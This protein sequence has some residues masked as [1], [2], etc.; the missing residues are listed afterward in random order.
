MIMFAVLG[1][2]LLSFT[3]ADTAPKAFEAEN[4]ALTSP[5]VVVSDSGASSGSYVDFGSSPSPAAFPSRLRVSGGRLLDENSTDVGTLKG[6][7]V[8]VAS[9]VGGES[10]VW[11]QADYNIMAAAGTKLVRHV[12]HWD[13]FE[14]SRGIFNQTALSSLDTAV[15]RAGQAGIYTV[16]DAPHLN[17]GRIP[18]WSQAGGSEWDAY[19]TNGQAL[20]QLLAN[21]YKDNK[22]VI[23]LYPNEPPISNISQIVSGHQTIVGWYGSIATEWPIWI[24]P[25]AWGGGTPYPSSAANVD[26]NAIAALDINS[27]GVIIEWHDYLNTAGSYTADGYQWNG[28]IAPVQQASEFTAQYHGWGGNY[29]YP[30]TA[31]SRADSAAHISPLVTL[32]NARSTFALAVG[33]F[34][35]DSQQSG[36]AAF[37]NDKSTLYT[38]S[39]A[40]VQLWWVYSVNSA[41]DPFSARPNNNWMPGIT[42]WLAAN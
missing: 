6:F 16:L 4:G 32:R 35:M 19:I 1:I 36:L 3:K 14:P 5:A 40:V 20:T 10:F 42:D 17:V 30:N 29:N 9:T 15:A 25:T 28:A 7:N 34:G 39:S 38:N 24:N 21:R 33:E 2:V 41:G 26:V 13:V 18:A 12:I 27:N 23:G 8:H 31:Q 22:F 37:V 11:P